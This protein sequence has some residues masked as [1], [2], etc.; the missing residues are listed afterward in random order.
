MTGWIKL[1]RE[2]LNNPIIARDAE[3]FAVW[4]YLLLNACYEVCRG[5]FGGEVIELGAGELLVSQRQ[6]CRDLKLDKSKVSR[7]LSLFKSEELIKTRTDK[8]KTLITIVSWDTEQRY[9]EIGND[10]GI[11]Q[12]KDREQDREKEKEKRRKR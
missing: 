4:A 11:R 5:V 7:I 6:I 9:S 8:Q 3:H 10:T 1:H 2:Y 12:E